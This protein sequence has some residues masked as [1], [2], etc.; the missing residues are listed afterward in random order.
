[1]LEYIRITV[2]IETKSCITQLKQFRLFSEMVVCLFSYLL[3]GVSLVNPRGV[4]IVSH[5][6]AGAYCIVTWGYTYRSKA[7]CL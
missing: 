4:L 5:W 1:M 6:G 3:G 2:S 7:V